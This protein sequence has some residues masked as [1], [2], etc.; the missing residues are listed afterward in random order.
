MTRKLMAFAA[1]RNG[2]GPIPR[3]A[4]CLCS[5]ALHNVRLHTHSF[6]Q[7]TMASWQAITEGPNLRTPAGA[8]SPAVRA[9][10]FIYVSGQVPFDAARDVMVSE[11]IAAETRQVIANLR[12]VLEAA[13]ASL[14]DVVSITAYLADIAD[15]DEFN[16]A[17]KQEFKRPFPTR[18][19]VG[20]G[21]HGFRVEM[22]A[23]AYLPQ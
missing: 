18:A 22:S 5:P 13:G 2:S 15:W 10:D 8:Y 11:S 3:V 20:A 6:M 21:L 17:Y 19:T 14:A 4:V 12:V 16:D 23:V 7:E 9:G 1:R